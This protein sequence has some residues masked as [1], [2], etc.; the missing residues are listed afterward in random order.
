VGPAG[1]LRGVRVALLLLVAALALAAPARAAAVGDCAP[2]ADW[3]APRPDLAAAVVGLAN[4]HRA[5]LGLPVLATSPTLTAA[6]TWKARHLAAFGYFAHDDPAP[7]VARTAGERIAACGYASPFVGE[8]IASGQ[9]SPAAVM[10][11]WLASPGHRAN[12]ERPAFAAIGVGVAAQ[13]ATLAW[14]QDFG[15]VA[16]PGS[17]IASAVAAPPAP[18]PPATGAPPAA[19]PLPAP[20][21]PPPAE[22]A[23]VRLRARCR[24]AGVRVVRCGVRVSRRAT[25]R[26]TLRRHG[27]TVAAAPVRR[28]RPGRAAKLRLRARGR[29]R[30][31]RYAVVLRAGGPPLRRVVRVR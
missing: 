11:S 18:A 1:S 6:A 17:V 15:D 24:V 7:P 14:V 23:V 10:A 22:E 12:L 31:G 28:V 3:P 29:L 8:N 27:R 5:A 9:P 30:A 20:V 16:D 25:V 2:A 26:A 19:Q 13:G 21:V 4:Q